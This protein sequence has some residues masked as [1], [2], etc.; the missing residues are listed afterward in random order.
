MT[1]EFLPQLRPHSLSTELSKE[2]STGFAGKGCDYIAPPR[3]PRRRL[4]GL[5]VALFIAAAVA[6][7]L[8]T[9]RFGLVPAG[10]GLAC[11]AGTWAAGLVLLLRDWVDDL[12]GR[13]A[14]FGCL[15]AGAI[16]SALT[17]GPALAVASAAAFAV[18]ELADWAVYRPLR[19]RGWAKAAL[20]S[21]VLGA[22]VDT[23]VFLTVAGLAAWPTLPGQMLAKTTVTVAVVAPVVVIRAVLRHR[24]R[25]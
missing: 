23:A 6:A 15:V 4:A 17:A 2:P 14:V 11:T 10:F 20:A 7:N 19:H 5:A 13:R 12:A 21:G 3:P 18:S 8:L 9:A 1:P 25:P 22:L 24:V 16:A